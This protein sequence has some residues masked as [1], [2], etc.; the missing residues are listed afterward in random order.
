MFK[1]KMF[2]IS[3]LMSFLIL[4]IACNNDSKK[5]ASHGHHH[6]NMIKEGQPKPLSFWWPERL[7]LS[8]LRQHSVESNPYGAKFDYAKEFKKVDLKQLKKDLAKVLT[9]SKDWW[10]A[11]WGHYGPLFIRMAWHSAGTY[12]VNDGRGGAG[13]GQQRFEPLNSWPDNGN[14]D[15][16]RRLLWPL[17]KKYGRKVSWADLMILAGTW[18]MDEMGFKTLGFAGGRADDW[19]ADLVYWGAE[20]K[21]LANDKRFHTKDKKKLKKPFGADHMGLIYV[22]PEGPN[23]NPDPKASALRI[24]ETFGRMAMNDEETLA[25]I[26]GGHTFGK[27]HGAHK[28]SK[29]VTGKEPGGAPL[30]EQQFG[31]KNECGK[32]HSEDTVTSGLEGAWTATPTQWSIQYLELLFKFDWELHEGSG[33]AKQWKPANGA[34]ANLVP[35]AHVKRKRNAPMMLT[36][37]LALKE[38]PIYNKIAKRFLENPKEF[39]DAFARAWFKLTHRDMG[40]RSR[41]VGADIPDD[42]MMWQDPIP[43][44]DHALIT[45]QDM[46]KLKTQILES[47]ISISEL[48][49]TAWASAASYR[50]TDMRGGANGARIRLA[51]QKDWQ[52]NEP[53]NLSATLE[54]LETLRSNFN[55]SLSGGKKVSMADTIVIAGAAAVESAA[56]KAGHKAK[57]DIAL[58]RTDAT[59]EMTNVTSFSYL[60]LKADPFRNYYVREGNLYSPTEAMVDRANLLGLT[61][62]ELTVLVGGMRVLGANY[63]NSQHGVFTDN[64][65]ALSND[66]FVN[67]LDMKYKWQK[68]STEGLYEGVMRDSGEKVFTATPVDLIFGSHSELRAVAEVYAA[69]DGAKKFVNDFVKAWTK[70]MRADRFDLK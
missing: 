6:Q 53:N 35:D 36:S 20:E 69:D 1:L 7:D 63:E 66:F 9:D 58:G 26:A 17:K 59:Q 54:K 62:P 57:V 68:S 12:R 70:V 18:A 55:K 29:C 47:G 56:K 49:K 2:S 38:D 8:P 33:G 34:A 24:R 25:L 27:A 60:E 40:P 46:A 13:G 31:W 10:P 3:L 23:G 32:G 22:N 19:E 16:A 51:P 30:E 52:V 28:A 48:V 50:N 43:K 15:K 61:V 11:D 44:R 39:E 14:L 4:S 65:G 67:L 37:D 5:S 64:V 41:Y 42:I 21:M 45:R